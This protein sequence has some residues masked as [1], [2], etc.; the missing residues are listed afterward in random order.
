[1]VLISVATLVY[2]AFVL[3]MLGFLARD[4]LK[5]RLL[6]LVGMIFYI[7]YYA[8]VAETPLWDP[9]LTNALLGAI[10]LAMI[11]VVILE[12]TTF[13]MSSDQ[14]RIF[15]NFG[16][17]SPGQFRRLL[18]HGKSARADRARTIVEEGRHVSQLAY[19]VEG[20]ARMKKGGQRFSMSAG[21]FIGEVGFVTGRPAS[22]T[23]EVE[24]GAHFVLWEVAKLEA[25]FKRHPALRNAMLAQINQDLANKVADGVPLAPPQ[26]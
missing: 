14:A 13:A 22:A 15:A 1:M 26:G 10:N 12:R 2:L 16:L 24:P 5:L 18:R 8:S 20:G 11:V 25:L 21:N 6:M 9:I 23:V 3:D 17:L 4:E 19:L 7:A